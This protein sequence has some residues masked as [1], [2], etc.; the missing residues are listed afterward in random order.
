MKNPYTASVFVIHEKKLLL[1]YNKKLNKWLQPGG[2]MN[3]EEGELPHEAAVRECEEET[4]IIT[5]LQDT[6]SNFEN[7]CP[8]PVAV[9]P[10]KTKIG[11]MFDLQYYGILKG[12]GKIKDKDAIYGWFTEREMIDMGVEPYIIKMFNYLVSKYQVKRVLRAKWN[13]AKQE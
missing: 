4:G 7:G 6:N 12:I 9:K 11:P 10:L 8:F 13:A 5:E 1:M 3:I 2:H